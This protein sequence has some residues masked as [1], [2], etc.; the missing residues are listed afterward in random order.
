VFSSH[1]ISSSRFPL[2]IVDG[3]VALS[4][5]IFEF[6]KKIQLPYLV[7]AAWQTRRNVDQNART[8]FRLPNAAA[9][10][11]RRWLRTPYRGASPCRLPFCCPS[12]TPVAAAPCSPHLPLARSSRSSRRCSVLDALTA[13]AR[14][15]RR[16]SPVSAFTND[17]SPGC[18]LCMSSHGSPLVWALGSDSPQNLAGYVKVYCHFHSKLHLFSP[19]LLKWHMQGGF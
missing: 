9:A 14:L 4:Y 19:L 1:L 8:R 18:L 11:T 7:V 12:L 15:S 10:S 17:C 2:A 5:L 13:R 6:C 16:H 3:K